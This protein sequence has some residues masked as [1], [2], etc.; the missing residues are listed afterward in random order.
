MPFMLPEYTQEPFTE[1]QTNLNGDTELIPSE[2]FTSELEG[3]IIDT[4]TNKWFCRLSA[5]GY[6]DCTDWS[7]PFDTL[8][9][10]Q[11]HIEETWDVDPET[12][13]SNEES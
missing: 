2:Y 4:Y 3:Y 9:E 10:A 1:W 12:G 6:L 8:K 13:E 11:E 5:P 7:G